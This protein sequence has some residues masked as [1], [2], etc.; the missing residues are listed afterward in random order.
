MFASFATKISGH[1][2]LSQENAIAFPSKDKEEIGLKRG[3]S[4]STTI[5]QRVPL[6][7]S[8]NQV[9]HPTAQV[10]QARA[11]SARPRAS[12]VAQKITTRHAP[13]PKV[14]HEENEYRREIPT[15]VNNMIADGG[16]M[17][18]A[19]S[20]RVPE[21]DKSAEQEVEAMVDVDDSEDEDE[22]DLG[23]SSP[24]AQPVRFWPEVSPEEAL[25]YRKEVE[26]VRERFEDSVSVQDT[27][28][29]SEYADDIF[30]Y[31]G[32]LEVCVSHLLGFPVS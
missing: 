12:V 20:D 8:R 5:A 7:P 26:A 29:V 4:N 22:D 30:D 2:K 31:M 19:P 25:H 24:E 9:A 17:L 13:Q 21:M 32:E 18:E 11:P 1:N 15:P 14:L 3:R 10:A 16:Y 23:H 28:L 27:S 6:G